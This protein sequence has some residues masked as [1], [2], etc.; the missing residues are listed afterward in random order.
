VT[1]KLENGFLFVLY[2]KRKKRNQVQKKKGRALISLVF[3]AQSA[4]NLDPHALFF[5]KKKE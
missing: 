3:Y 5:G 4:Y 2:I 1:W